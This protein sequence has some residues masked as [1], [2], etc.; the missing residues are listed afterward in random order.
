LTCR[1]INVGGGFGVAHGEKARGLDIGTLAA[2]LVPI[3][4]ALHG[5]SRSP[6]KVVFELGRFLTAP[7]GVYVVRVIRSKVSRGKS[8]FITDGGLHHHLGAAGTFGMALRSN[9]AL[10]NISRPGAPTVRCCVAGPSCN[11]TDLLGVDVDLPQPEPGDLI[12]VLNAG[13]YGFTA[14]PVLFLGRPTPAE[15]IRH[16]GKIVLGRRPRTIGDFN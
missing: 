3:L 7:A 11:P 2:A 9:Y 14:S 6:R 13:S 10:Q 5:S 1:T 15:L 4:R 8:F 12:A 16:N